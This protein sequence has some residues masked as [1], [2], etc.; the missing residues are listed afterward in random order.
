MF[1]TGE[2]G[3]GEQVDGA[4][5]RGVADGRSR[6]RR[7]VEVDAAQELRREERPGVMRDAVGIRPGNAVELDVV[8]A[9]GETAEVG[10]GLAEADAVAVGGEGAGGHLDSLAVV[11]YRAT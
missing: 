9:V 3:L 5:E 10:L 4:A 7:A 2:K 11:G 6:A 1:C 8:V